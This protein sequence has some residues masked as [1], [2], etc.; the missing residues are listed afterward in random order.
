M[1]VNLRSV[2]LNDIFTVGSLLIGG[3][4]AW[5]LLSTRVSALETVTQDYGPTSKQIA[6]LSQ[7]LD[8]AIEQGKE[9]RQEIRE[10]RKDLSG[11]SR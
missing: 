3:T 4:V 1:K 6:I 10:L 5:T 2:T 9:T 8:D 11:R 7:K